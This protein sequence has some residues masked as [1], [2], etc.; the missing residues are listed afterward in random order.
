MNDIEQNLNHMQRLLNE[1][2][3]WIDNAEPSE[4]ELQ[5]EMQRNLNSLQR[6]LNDRQRKRYLDSQAV[7]ESE[8]LNHGKN[9]KEE[10]ETEERTKH[11]K[12]QD[13]KFG[14]ITHVEIDNKVIDLNNIK[15]NKQKVNKIVG[16][17]PPL[18]ILEFLQKSKPLFFLSLTEKRKGTKFKYEKDLGLYS[19]GSSIEKMVEFLDLFFDATKIPFKMEFTKKNEEIL[20]FY[21]NCNEY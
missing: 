6:S 12:F 21:K 17:V 9:R 2:Q 4:Y 14:H 18:L 3:R 11:G 16:S 7:N 13:Y 1:V 5:N 8:T 15:H 20:Y 10:S 19:R